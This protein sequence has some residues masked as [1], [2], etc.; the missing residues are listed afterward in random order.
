MPANDRILVHEL[1]I[2]AFASPKRGQKELDAAYRKLKS[3]QFQAQLLRAA[4]CI[5]KR[6][7]ILHAV[8]LKIST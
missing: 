6:H 3:R 2:S 1:H 5:C 4:R 8:V 7:R